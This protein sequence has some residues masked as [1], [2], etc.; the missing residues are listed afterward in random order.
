MN[1]NFSL[2]QRLRELR[3]ARAFSQEQI[4]NIAGIV[5]AYLGQVER[6]EKNITVKTLEKVCLALNITL[7]EFFSAVKEQDKNIDEISNQILHQLI[8]KTKSEKKA[9]LKLVKLVFSIQE[10]RF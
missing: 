2:G 7:S 9:I 8:G 4:A 6:G 5:P 3:Q 10:M 1:D